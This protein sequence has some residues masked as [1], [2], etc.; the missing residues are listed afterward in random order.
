MRIRRPE[1]LLFAAFGMLAF[2]AGIGF[3]QRPPTAPLP[4]LL[5]E[6]DKAVHELFYDPTL[7]GVD[8]DG[9]LR[10]A[11]QELSQTEE[12]ARQ[13]AIYDRLLATLEDS[14]TFRLPPGRLPEHDWWTAG[15]RMG[16]DGDGYAVKG[17]VPG[18]A[19]DAAGLRIGDRILA[20][21]GVAYG[22]SRVSFRDLFFVF[23]GGPGGS[24]EVTWQRPGESVRKDRLALKPEDPGE[25]LVWK[26]AR[27]IRRDGKNW[28]YV[29]LWGMSAETALAVVDLLLDRDEV[30]RSRPGLA[31]W[32]EIEGLIL[33]DR[34]NSGGY[35]P[36]ILPTFLRGQWSSGDY[37]KISRR[38]KRLVPPV[39]KTLPVVLLIN[40]GTASAG[41]SLALKF[42]AH[43]IGPLVGEAT[44]GMASGGANPTK[45]SD[46]SML[47]LAR[48]AIETLDGK[49]FEGRGIEPDVPV[50]DRP[51][52]RAGQE[53]AVIEA[54]LKT[55]AAATAPA[56]AP[57][58]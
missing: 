55:L 50:A 40:S 42:R 58:R 8:W 28:G 9:A 16:Q 52:A 44:S 34:G 53:E 19:A 31:G 25:A 51:A 2:G 4:P 43:G 35:D 7:K 6:I 22:K 15:L 41:E 21:D 36:N 5:A 13:D 3:A 24:V 45:L 11:A 20:V 17:V 14:H 33:D 49:S 10:K 54:G 39:Y 47:W 57:A 37:Y 18:G 46:G 32:N 26:S 29:R 27:V 48:E 30:A 1:R 38:G 12:K 23:E 56:A